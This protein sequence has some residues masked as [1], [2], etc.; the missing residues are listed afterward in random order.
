[1]NKIRL[2]FA[3]VMCFVTLTA[4]A[5]LPTITSI[6]TTERN[7]ATWYIIKN[8]KT[9]EYLRYE[10]F[11][12]S[13]TTSLNLDTCAMF[14]VTGGASA[15]Y[16][17]NYAAG[18][19]RVCV[20]PNKWDE[21]GTAF[22]I[23]TTTGGVF[24]SQSGNTAASDAFHYNESTGKVDLY[25]GSDPNS[26]WVFEQITDFADIMGLTKLIDDAYNTVNASTSWGFE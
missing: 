24:I 16:I 12:F 8:A 11:K 21:S 1:M 7:N 2:I 15:A 26:V 25:L 14:Y 6:E 5:Q 10:G 4:V 3:A 17:H 13:M 18:T 9:G 19:Q 22:Q 20:A 23:K